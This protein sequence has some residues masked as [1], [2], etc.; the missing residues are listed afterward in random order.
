MPGERYKHRPQGLS[1]RQCGYVLNLAQGMSRR[2]A[3]LAAGYSQRS[4]EN[5]AHAVEGKRR[6][7]FSMMRRFVH[8]LTADRPELIGTEEKGTFRHGH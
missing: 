1:P 3:A 6:G 5:V 7:R 2:G 8:L 4:A